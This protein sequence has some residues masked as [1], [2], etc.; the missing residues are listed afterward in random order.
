MLAIG[1]ALAR[2]PAMQR[3]LWLALPL[4]VTGCSLSA[5]ITDPDV[6]VTLTG[7][8]ARVRVEFS[9]API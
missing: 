8:G 7:S 4:V 1:W 3:A 5:Q 2:C 6:T 9:L